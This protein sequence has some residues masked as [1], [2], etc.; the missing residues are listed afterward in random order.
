MTKAARAGKQVRSSGAGPGA[1]DEGGND[2]ARD[3]R[4]SGPAYRRARPRA[5]E[6]RNPSHLGQIE[7]HRRHPRRGP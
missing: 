1:D 2:E 3:S 5:G 7:R 4:R 6:H